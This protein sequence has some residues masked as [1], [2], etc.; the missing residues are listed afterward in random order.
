MH[1]SYGV[2]MLSALALWLKKEDGKKELLR[3]KVIRKKIKEANPIN[4]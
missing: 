2:G 3:E 4:L 1:L